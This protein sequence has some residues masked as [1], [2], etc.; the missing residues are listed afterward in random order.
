[1]KRKVITKRASYRE[2]CEWIALNDNA[3]DDRI[4]SG[5]ESQQEIRKRIA[6]YIST[7][8]VADIFGAD[9]DAVAFD[10]FRIRSVY[11]AKQDNA[12]H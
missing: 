1:M 6:G 3:G 10:I 11:F 7:L 9:P 8:L 4:V 12:T 5:E 2:A